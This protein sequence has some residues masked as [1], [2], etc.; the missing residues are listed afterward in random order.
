MHLFIDQGNTRVKWRFVDTKQRL[1]GSGAA[2]K[3]DWQAII[4]AAAEVKVQVEE[5]WVASVLDA[6][7]KDA[8]AKQLQNAFGFAANFASVQASCLGVKPAYKDL[9]KLGVDRWLGFLAAYTVCRQLCVVISV[10]T[11][12]TVDFIDEAGQHAGGLIF[13]GVSLMREAL[14]QKS[15]ALS[16]SRIE[17]SNGWSPGCTTLECIEAGL[18]AGV[19]GFAKQIE[20]Y[21]SDHWQG[22]KV[23]VTGGDAKVFAAHLDI[24]YTLR[25]GL[26]LDGLQLVSRA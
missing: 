26:V 1:C 7:A 11:A 12:M 2:D 9:S 5:V 25:D 3:S 24:P 10:G 13:P 18:N 4:K 22:A 19:A 16:S 23:M 21:V 15:F 6:S 14:Q 8:F 20:S 17:M